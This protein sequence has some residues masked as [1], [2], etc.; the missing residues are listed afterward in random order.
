[1]DKQTDT[2][3]QTDDRIVEI[4]LLFQTALDELRKDK[5]T[6]VD[7]ERLFGLVEI[8]HKF[9]EQVESNDKRWR[10]YT[11]ELLI[12]LAE[13]HEELSS[14]MKQM[15]DTDGPIRAYQ[16]AVGASNKIKEE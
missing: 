1:M 15:I 16:K 3:L 10:D 9:Y 5:E 12:L 6:D 11:E 4:E 8:Y 14:D 13:S 7:F 2:K